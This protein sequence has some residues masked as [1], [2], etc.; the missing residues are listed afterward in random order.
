MQRR[1]RLNRS[2]DIQRVRRTGKSYAHPL[3]VLIAARSDAPVRRLAITAG[4]RVGGAVQRNRARRRIREA[5]RPL[6]AG[7]PDG[8]DLL[9]IARSGA[10][11]A[12][13]GEL[14][15]AVRALF[16]RAGVTASDEREKSRTG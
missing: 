13:F 4:L 9:L 14:E 8:W 12:P 1:F 3:L 5:A 16:Q 10:V 7:I 2:G 11:K 15:N 6:V